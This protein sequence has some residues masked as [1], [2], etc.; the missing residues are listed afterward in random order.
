MPRQ[1]TLSTNALG[2]VS[3][4]VNATF[5]AYL[6]KWP[7]NTSTSR[8]PCVVV[9]KGPM[10]SIPVRSK[11]SATSSKTC[12]DGDATFFGD[13]W[14]QQDLHATPC[15]FI[16]H[17]IPVQKYLAAIRDGLSHSQVPCIGRIMKTGRFLAALNSEEL[18][19]AV[20]LFRPWFSALS[21]LR[22]DREFRIHLS[23]I[24]AYLSSLLAVHC[25][26]TFSNPPSLACS[27]RILAA[28]MIRINVTVFIG[29]RPR[30][31]AFRRVLLP[32]I[33]FPCHTP[34]A[35]GFNGKAGNFGLDNSL[36]T[37]RPYNP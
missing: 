31:S 26:M 2:L 29:T 15:S 11:G 37:S 33:Q 35:T 8:F 5:S 12:T 10:T 27:S 32:C 21:I 30:A 1:T 28:S 6:A 18:R 3:A 24:L 19:Y 4:S 13:L 34:E 36:T 23:K 16:T 22:P 7:M 20:T 14:R 17:G 25:R 9:R